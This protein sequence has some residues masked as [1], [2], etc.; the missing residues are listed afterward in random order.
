M[1]LLLNTI[2]LGRDLW[3]APPRTKRAAEPS[4]LHDHRRMCLKTSNMYEKTPRMA[5]I[6]QLNMS[7]WLTTM[8]ECKKAF[9][10][11]IIVSKQH[12]AEP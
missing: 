6:Y 10:S 8:E 7:N 11:H 12:M 5:L 4:F 1:L 2:F 3:L 9:V